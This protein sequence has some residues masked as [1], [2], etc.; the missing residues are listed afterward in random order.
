MASLNKFVGSRG[1]V[2]FCRQR[3][4][5]LLLRTHGA[6]SRC[7]QRAKAGASTTNDTNSQG[8]GQHYK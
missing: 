4:A 8:Q 3:V 2:Q 6:C 5:H 1:A 7:S